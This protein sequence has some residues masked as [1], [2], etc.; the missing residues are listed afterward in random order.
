M[1]LPL[2]IYFLL[3]EGITII[4]LQFIVLSG[5]VHCFYWYFLSR[6]YEDGDLSHVYPIMRSSPAIV[7]L[8]AITLL[9]EKVTTLGVL[10]M[11]TILGGVYSINLQRISGRGFLE[12]LISF[13]ERSTQYALLT[14]VTVAMY[15]ITDKIAVAHVHPIVFVYCITVFVMIFNTVYVFIVKKRHLVWQ[16][17]KSHPKMIISNGFLTMFSYLLILFALT[18]ERT[19]YVTSIRQLSVV[20]GVIFGG[21]ILREKHAMIR[22]SASL[23]ILIGVICIALAS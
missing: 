10:G 17:L 23:L 2:F 7:F 5:I 18:F 6:A 16:E 9:G 1:Y 4:G 21:H 19:S 14:A 12:P 20:F 13:R 11:C 8:L 15:S 22:L 3:Q